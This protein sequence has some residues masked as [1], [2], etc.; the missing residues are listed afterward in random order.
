MLKPPLLC[1][2]H[3]SFPKNCPCTGTAA[4]LKTNSETAPVGAFVKKLRFVESWPTGIVF[5]SLWFGSAPRNKSSEM[6]NIPS[7]ILLHSGHKTAVSLMEMSRVRAQNHAVNA[8]RRLL[9]WN[10]LSQQSCFPYYLRISTQAPLLF[11]DKK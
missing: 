4:V 1:L 5:G 10:D 2:T 9:L 6:L 8:V 7:D 3:F 11:L